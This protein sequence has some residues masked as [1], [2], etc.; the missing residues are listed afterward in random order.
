MDIS[1]KYSGFDNKL[2]DS[3]SV[4]GLSLSSGLVIIAIFIGGDLLSFIDI[5]SFLIVAG[6]TFGTTLFNFP[7]QDLKRSFSSLEKVFS[8]YELTSIARFNKILDLAKK[9][10]EQGTLSLEGKIFQESDPFFRK[11]IQLLVDGFSAEDIE[12]NLEIELIQT[13][14]KQRRE[15]Q[16]F[17]T[18]GTISPAM[19]LIGTLVGLV[20]MLKNLSDPAQLGPG[21]ATALLTTF[22]GAI[23]A[24]MIF[25]PI[26][27]KL[28]AKTE[29]D[30][31]IK[32]MTIE[33][34]ME[35]SRS[36]NPKLIEHKLLAFLPSE[37]RINQFEF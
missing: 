12:R 30:L 5:K 32:A 13:D 3:S 4:L 1:R 2:L 9:S 24:Y 20:H 28:K 25:I 8:E 16:V 18:M 22:Y 31:T 29:E 17:Y 21:M 26:A 7:I 11:A 23:L 37:V 19:G 10:K 14:E 36:T 27:G 34:I 6:G 33:G 15:A 35:I